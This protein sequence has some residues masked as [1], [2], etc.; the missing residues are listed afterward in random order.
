MFVEKHFSNLTINTV[1]MNIKET[2]NSSLRE[3]SGSGFSF[4][5][6]NLQWPIRH[7]TGDVKYGVFCKSICQVFGDGDIKGRVLGV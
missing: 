6:I 7:W 4:G 1:E 2:G 3:F 5:Q